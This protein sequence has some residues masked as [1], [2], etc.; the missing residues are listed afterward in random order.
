MTFSNYNLPPKSKICLTCRDFARI[1][2][3]MLRL[4]IRMPKNDG[5]FSLFTDPI[6]HLPNSLCHWA[7]SLCSLL[8]VHFQKSNGQGPE[9]V[10]R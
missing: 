2:F 5:P 8:A 6:T 9:G 7:S 10:S 4:A 3:Q 1:S